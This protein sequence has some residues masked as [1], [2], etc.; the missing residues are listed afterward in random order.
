MYILTAYVVYSMIGVST[1][2]REGIMSTVY[3]LISILSVSMCWVIYYY[4]FRDRN[5]TVFSIGENILI[6]ILFLNCMIFAVSDIF[7]EGNWLTRSYLQTYILCVVIFLLLFG[8]LS[9]FDIFYVVNNAVNKNVRGVIFQWG[10]IS[11]LVFVLLLTCGI[12][13]IFSTSTGMGIYIGCCILLFA[14]IVIGTILIIKNK[15][16][17]AKYKG[18]VLQTRVYEVD[19]EP[20]QSQV[21]Q[22]ALQNHARNELSQDAGQSLASQHDM[23]LD[24]DEKVVEIPRGAGGSSIVRSRVARSRA[25]RS[26]VVQDQ[27]QFLGG[28]TDEGD[29]EDMYDT[30]SVQDEL[31]KLRDGLANAEKLYNKAGEN[32][33]SQSEI[34]RL[35]ETIRKYKGAIADIEQQQKLKE[36]SS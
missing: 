21:N 32:G 12:R 15:D 33:S 27:K 5:V 23:I 4:V 30:S 10:Y 36:G 29:E 2:I 3:V 13:K 18:Q 19:E 7:K 9:A 26:P 28:S 34:D 22:S 1:K 24:N 17:I 14:V 11:I 25:V 35:G 6:T 8:L 16:E 31:E 20:P